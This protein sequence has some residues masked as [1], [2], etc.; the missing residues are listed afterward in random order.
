VFS[1][2]KAE[3]M[4]LARTTQAMGVR[5][6]RLF[7]EFAERGTRALAEAHSVSRG[8]FESPF[9]EAVATALAR[10]GWKL[11]TQIGASTFR[12]D[13]SV[14][15]PDAQGVYL[16]GIECDGA[17]YHRSATARDRDKLREQV[18]RGLGWDILRVW[19][20]DWWI[21]AAGTLEK[22][23]AKLRTL[24]EISRVKR[25]EAAE[26]EAARL[27]AAE[28]IIKAMADEAATQ[29]LN[30]DGSDHAADSSPDTP[31]S[32]TAQPRETAEVYAGHISDNPAISTVVFIEADPLSVVDGT[33]VD[34]FFDAAYDPTLVRMIA[35]VVE[36]EGPVLDGVLARRIA[37]AH[38]WQRTG[39]RI[40]ERVEALAARQFKTTKEDVGTFYWP[41][42]RT[43][44]GSIAFRCPSED[45]A[46]AVDEICMAE[47][48][49][50]AK[51]VMS[52]GS[53]GEDV[54]TAMAREIGLHQIRA[55]SRGRLEKVMQM[56]MGAS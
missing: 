48:G 8:G 32:G 4:D 11:H 44:D 1:S 36:I 39:S 35:H 42:G 56:V 47:L 22:L 14:V 34:A 18:L 6:L 53:L 26:K 19:S 41:A 45:A 29:Q 54:I 9:E 24:L 7:L 49:A 40:R 28:A 43:P 33:N 52:D 30:E 5:D 21:D 25:A 55:A 46:R 10:K 17:T 50:L 20:T 27:A 31:Q 51:K 15:H 38:G 2:L 13:L 12:I 37:R 3:Q 23:D 16:C